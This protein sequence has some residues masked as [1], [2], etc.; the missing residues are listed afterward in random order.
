MDGIELFEAE[1]WEC[2]FDIIHS[3]HS[4]YVRERTLFGDYLR[5]LLQQNTESFD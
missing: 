3:L 5:W 4:L 1:I 2:G